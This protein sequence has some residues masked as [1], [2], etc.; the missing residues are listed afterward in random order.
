MSG[1]LGTYVAW[2]A[3]VML[4]FLALRGWYAGDPRRS[5]LVF[6]VLLFLACPPVALLLY[7]AIRFRLVV[8]HR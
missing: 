1:G 5:Q 6:W 3:V 4:A 7:V 8:A 2:V